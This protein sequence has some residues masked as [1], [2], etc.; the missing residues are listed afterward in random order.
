MYDSTCPLCIRT[1]ITPQ[2]YEDDKFVVTKCK[3]CDKWMFLLKEHRREFTEDELRFGKELMTELVGPGS[4]RGYKKEIMDH[5]HEHWNLSKINK[6]EERKMSVIAELLEGGNPRDLLL[7]E[8]TFDD[9]SQCLDIAVGRLDEISIFSKAKGNFVTA[10]ER[11]SSEIRKFV[12]RVAVKL[13]VSK[14][15]LIELL[16]DKGVFNFF[17]SFK[18]ELEKAYVAVT[19]FIKESGPEKL[20]EFFNNLVEYSKLGRKKLTSFLLYHIKLSNL[21]G[22]ALTGLLFL[23]HVKMNSVLGTVKKISLDAAKSDVVKKLTEIFIKLAGKSRILTA[24]ITLFTTGFGVTMISSLSKFYSYVISEIMLYRQF[25]ASQE[26][27]KKA[28]NRNIDVEVGNRV[29]DALINQLIV[30]LKQAGRSEKEAKLLIR[31][32]IDKINAEVA[33]AAI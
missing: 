31:V 26:A 18:F 21:S 30:S 20:K 23:L 9:Y 4:F 6:G 12:D 13:K 16:R 1:P 25:K 3:N 32:F 28:K 14:D 27:E 24:V 17:K 15:A 5:A 19:A 2:I 7:D 22:T 33:D 10:K 29:A 11:I 8:F